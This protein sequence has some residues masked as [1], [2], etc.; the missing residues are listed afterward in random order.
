SLHTV[1]SYVHGTEEAIAATQTSQ[2]HLFQRPDTFRLDPTRTSLVG[3]GLGWAIGR[4]GDTKH[5]RYGLAGSV[6]T[7]GLELNDAGFQRNTDLF[8][9]GVFVRYHEET[10]PDTFL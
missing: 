7:P 4:T 8:I 2:V 9:N 6:T 3:G 10:P 1:G 5:W